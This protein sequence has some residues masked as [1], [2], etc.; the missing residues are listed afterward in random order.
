[1]VGRRVTAI[2]LLAVVGAGCTS[3]PLSNPAS[4]TASASIPAIVERPRFEGSLPV[5]LQP[6]TPFYLDPP[7]RPI[8]AR[9][10]ICSVDGAATYLAYPPGRRAHLIKAGMEPNDESTEWIVTLT[11]D[12]A[13]PGPIS[14]QALSLGGAL[15]VVS[16]DNEVLVAHRPVTVPVRS[17]RGSVVHLKEMDKATAWDLVESLNDTV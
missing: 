6:G 1:M 15:L 10:R 12:S 7:C 3:D 4:T 14:R 8:P 5:R 13:A 9:S 2:V 17:V 16:T 11:F